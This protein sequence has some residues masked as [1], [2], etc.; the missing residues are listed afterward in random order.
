VNVSKETITPKKAMEWLKRNVQ[1]RPLSQS[2]VNHY[3]KAMAVGEWKLNGDT[4]RFNGNGDLIDGQHRLTACVHSGKS[5]ESYVIRGLAHDAFDTID[6][7]RKRT[8]GDVFARQGYKHYITLASAVRWLWVY[9][10]IQAGKP[11]VFRETI[12]ADQ[13]NDVLEKHPALHAAVEK[14]RRFGGGKQKLI[15]HGAL[16][17]LIYYTGQKDEARA[18]E[19]WSAVVESAGLK[20][21]SPAYLLN[22]RL[23]ANLG[24]VAKLNGETITALAIKAWNAFR[25]NK[26]CGTLKWSDGEEFPKI[27]L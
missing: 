6:Q 3:G 19:F 13:A 21:E 11:N 5:F 4:I 20:R 7:G 9:E 26:P 25:T 15:H 22:K 10:N 27:I 1:N 17:F 2:L 18:D 16:A 14:A 24:S 23:I 8:I 12:R